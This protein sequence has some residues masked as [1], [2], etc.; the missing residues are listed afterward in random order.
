ML[1]PAAALMVPL[2]V[3]LRL[4]Y[5][6]VKRAQGRPNIISTAGW[7]LAELAVPHLLHLYMHRAV[8]LQ[9]AQA[10]TA[11]N[12]ATGA[13]TGCKE[14]PA[15]ASAKDKQQPSDKHDCVLPG[16]GAK[17]T[18]SDSSSMGAPANAPAGAGLAAKELKKD[19]SERHAVNG[20]SGMGTAQ[21]RMGHVNA[22]A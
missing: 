16:G 20:S 6:F 22:D 19:G 21:V 8:Q 1:V 13:S 11:V 7:V 3:H 18:T 2:A 12:G 10:S 5:K 9:Q 15:S 4:F 17:A 14:A